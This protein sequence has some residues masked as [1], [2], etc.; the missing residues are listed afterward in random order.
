[1]AHKEIK[2]TLLNK[3]AHKG[4]RKWYE[5]LDKDRQRPPPAKR[6]NVSPDRGSRDQKSGGRLSSP[7]PEQQRPEFQGSRGFAT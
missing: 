4:S 3:A 2:L 1:M 6:A 7:K 5:P